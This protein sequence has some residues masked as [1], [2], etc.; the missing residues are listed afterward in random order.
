MT[1][2]VFCVYR[3]GGIYDGEWVTRLWNGIRQSVKQPHY[4]VCLTDDRSYQAPHVVIR[5]NENWPGW[6]SKIE[7]FRRDLFKMFP[8]PT[9]Y[10]DLDSIITGN[11]DDLFRQRPGFTMVPDFY[12]GNRNSSVMSWYGDFSPIYRKFQAQPEVYQD[13]YSRRSDGRIGDQAFIE[14]SCKG[15]D[16]FEAGRV[17]SYK[18]HARHCL[19]E[20]AAIVQF[21]GS[22]KPH[23]VK[24]GWP[25]QLW[26]ER[27]S[28]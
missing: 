12:T 2:A 18:K 16:T 28:A 25:N 11:L 17:I 27:K 9:L 7:L 14:D 22:P 24:N 6:W 20:D 21:H 15:I 8:M 26:N 13:A 23:E 4:F 1:V 5:L 19:P 3:T 10:V